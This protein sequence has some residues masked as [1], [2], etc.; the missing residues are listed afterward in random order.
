MI[1]QT[2]SSQQVKPAQATD[3]KKGPRIAITVIGSIAGL[4]LFIALCLDNLAHYE[5]YGQ[6][7]ICGFTHLQVEYEDAYY[8]WYWWGY[9]DG[10]YA[11]ADYCDSTSP[12]F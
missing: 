7:E 8:W 11:Y 5:S 9:L 4:L 1:Q 12:D 3:P 6:E 10:D 2:A